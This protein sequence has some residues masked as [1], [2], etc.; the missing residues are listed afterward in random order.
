MKQIICTLI[1]SL[2]MIVAAGVYS[3]HAQTGMP[4]ILGIQTSISGCSWSAVTTYFSS[5]STVANG[6]AICPINSTSGPQLAIAVNG[7]AFVPIP[8][9]ASAP[10]ASVFGRTGNVIKAQGDYNYADLGS[11]PT[12]ISCTAAQISAG[13]SGTLSGTG[14]TIK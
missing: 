3:V 2:S 12:T 4:V 6:L 14:C 10:V 11:P 7:G 9:T 1:L 5:G 8:M 13:A